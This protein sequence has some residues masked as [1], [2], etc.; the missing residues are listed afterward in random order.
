[1]TYALSPT[2]AT[3]WR[4]KPY[5]VNSFVHFSQPAIVLDASVNQ[6]SFTYPVNQITYDNVV[7][8]SHSNAA[9]GMT[10]C[11]Y[12]STGIIKG[13]T[14]VRLAPTSNTIYIGHVSNGEIEFAD[15]DRVVIYR[16]FRIFSRI[17]YINP[18]TGEQF[19][20]LNISYSNQ[21]E[22]IPPKANA[23]VWIA[24]KPN[25]GNNLRVPLH[26]ASSFAVAEGA[27]ISSRL[28]DIQDGTLITGALTDTDITV[29]FPAGERWISLTVTDSNGTTHTAYSLIVNNATPLEVEITSLSGSL[30]GGGW[31]MEV[32]IN[33]DSIDILPGT[34]VIHWVEEYFGTEDGGLAGYSDRE[35][36]RFIGWVKDIKRE[37]GP[38][39]DSF[40]VKFIGHAARLQEIPAFSNTLLRDATPTVWH[41]VE[42]LTHWKA[43]YHQIYWHTT[44][45]LMCD[46][47]RPTYYNNY[48]VGGL[49]IDPSTAF[50]QL[51]Q[52]SSN[53]GAKFTVNKHGILAFHS[54]NPITT[55]G[56]KAA[57]VVVVDLT[58]DDWLEQIDIATDI[59]PKYAWIFGQ[60]LLA[61]ASENP[62][63]FLCRAP[64]N[65]PSQGGATETVGRQLVTSQAELNERIGNY[66]ATKNTKY[67][68]ITI[69]VAH[70]G[71]VVDPCDLQYVTLT[72]DSASNKSG[73]AL[74]ESNCLVTS[75]SIS[76]DNE[77]ANSKETWT[78]EIEVDGPDA[79]T[80][81]IPSEDTETTI[82]YN[83]I[84]DDE[85]ETP[86]IL[87]PH[88]TETEVPESTYGIAFS[89]SNPAAITFNRD[90]PTWDMFHNPTD[91][92]YVS[93][94]PDEFSPYFFNTS[95]V[96]N[97]YGLTNN[98][99]DNEV[100][101]YYIEDALSETP[102]FNQYTL[103]STE[104]VGL[105]RP[106]RGVEGGVGVYI[107]SS[108]FAADDIVLTFDGGSDP[109]YTVTRGTVGGTGRSGI[110]INATN[111]SALV[112]TEFRIDLGASYTVTDI[113]LWVYVA[114]A[115]AIHTVTMD[116]VGLQS[117]GTTQ[118]GSHVMNHP[119]TTD[120]TWTEITRNG[121]TWN[122]TRYLN[123]AFQDPQTW[124]TDIRVD[125]I[126][127][128]IV[129]TSDMAS[130]CYSDDFG[131][132]NVQ[133]GFGT[134]IDEFGY[135]VDDY[136]LGISIASA[137]SGTGSVLYY[138]NDDYSEQPALI[139]DIA[140]SGSAIYYNLIRIPY[141]R[142]SNITQPNN[143][144]GFL[145]FILGS[146]DAIAGETLWRVVFDADANN[147]ISTTDITPEISSELYAI[148]P[149]Y[150][151]Q[152]ETNGRD[153]RIMLGCFRN[154]TDDTIHV[155]RTDDAGTTWEDCGEYDFHFVRFSTIG[156]ESAWFAGAEGIYY[157]GDRGDTFIDKTTNYLTDIGTLPIGGAF[158]INR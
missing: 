51:K 155:L 146:S 63:P 88:E 119:T 71:A 87:I 140:N 56:E 123:I 138:T 124:L 135:D 2:E 89:F 102:T 131:A 8:G 117:D 4:T 25:S 3:I 68:P 26:S 72:V 60:G 21:N 148:V 19:K 20:D 93:L 36:I 39:K 67:S 107:N 47:L 61:S 149:G 12:S 158:S 43:I 59:T 81:L 145:E 157:T 143:S 28:W 147:V 13:F 74:D 9:F 40:R 38:F 101:L 33:E 48:P 127:T 108:E 27:T 104:G 156:T 116:I 92:E 73:F 128:T 41:E 45:H 114:Y 110:C 14:R 132:T 79:V 49:D 7:A 46:I 65:S 130:I 70:A 144:S 103:S 113:S 58:S 90:N 94:I 129:G 23:G 100:N 152:L 52:L 85:Y 16:D 75:V 142:P 42:A 32:V 69:K 139:T 54:Y 29:D 105:A 91:E 136:N 6:A 30:E 97:M 66:Y 121:M 141:K 125:D 76:Y 1:M 111:V 55:A 115:Q 77:Q 5:F 120:A 10:V 126:S 78:L 62:T 150:G 22:N 83:P 17:P 37:I 15:N 98:P 57:K 31:E 86:D 35:S 53:V 154:L 11:V 82:D 112:R 134:P 133:T 153:S 44:A 18:D 151:E 34:P 109:S 96:L 106:V 84:I 122:N 99:T 95:D 24:G 80:E 137:G 50:N 118:T 64:G